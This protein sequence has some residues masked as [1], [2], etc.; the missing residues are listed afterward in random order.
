MPQGPSTAPRLLLG[1]PEPPASGPASRA[2]KSLLAALTRIARVDLCAAGP[3]QAERA[4]LMASGRKD[5]VAWR[6][7]DPET[8][9]SLL[10]QRIAGQAYDAILAVDG[11]E[12]RPV[13][14][15][16][17]AFAGR[18]PVVVVSLPGLYPQ[19]APASRRRPLARPPA[20]AWCFGGN[21]A[22][23]SARELLP[24]KI[25]AVKAPSA[26]WVG[27]RLAGLRG[28]GA[29]P[30]KPGT[31][32]VVIPCWNGLAYTKDC[33]RGV[34]AESSLDFEV[35]VVDNGS[36]D[37]TAEFV[38]SLKDPRLSLIRNERNL[39]FARAV[40]QGLRRAS[41][42]HAVWLNNDTVVTAGWLERLLAGLERAP[43]VGAVGPYTNETSGVQKLQQVPYKTLDGLP[44]FAAAWAMQHEGRMAWAHRLIGFCLA[45]RRSVLDEIGFLDE[46]FG[47]GTYEDFDFCLRLR[48]AG[49]EL[50]VAED[51]FVHHHGHKSFDANSVG[52]LDQ[53]HRNREVFVDKWCR[54]SLALLDEADALLVSS[55]A[56]RR[57][58]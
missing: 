36:T 47:L 43:W 3:S 38:R 11:P 29:R 30:P 53:V 17:T 35:I 28:V 20:E 40:N 37:G 15:Q 55:A 5:R 26:S 2:L 8:F 22:A 52:F 25:A 6:G 34:L 45:H 54:H 19:A 31:A 10:K 42:R 57:R 16:L 7:A 33:L 12:L 14:G 1:L 41:G 18:T 9:F 23:E 24:L 13:L 50:F 21:G 44:A 46:R 49:Y 48:Q 56:R 32:S 51:A 27:S 4:A 58:P 39:G